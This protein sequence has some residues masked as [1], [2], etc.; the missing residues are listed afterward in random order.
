MKDLAVLVP[1]EPSYLF[2]KLDLKG[3]VITKEPMANGTTRGAAK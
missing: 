1:A 3:C 2:R